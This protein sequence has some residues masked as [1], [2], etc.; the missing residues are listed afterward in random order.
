VR[1]LRPGGVIFLGDL[2]SLSLLRAFHASVQLHRANAKT[3]VADVRLR[4]EQQ[5]SQ[6]KELVFD[7]ELFHAIRARVGEIAAV[8]VALK[9]GHARN[10][11]TAFRYDVTLRT[12]SDDV[13]GN[14]VTWL[15]WV[16]KKLDL[17]GVRQLLETHAGNCFAI[18]GVPNARLHREHRA[19][20]LLDAAD[21]SSTVEE[22]RSD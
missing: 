15:D 10:E 12:R 3:T 5:I 1:T 7:P 20:A 11:L 18:G 8:E 13:P 6:E 22:L 21:P 17:V 9:R 16:D 2:R 4:L 19:P 14:D